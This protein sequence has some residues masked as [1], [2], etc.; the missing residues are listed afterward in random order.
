ML[1]SRAKQYPEEAIAAPEKRSS[2]DSA[3]PSSSK[4]ARSSPAAASSSALASTKSDDVFL[5]ALDSCVGSRAV[6]YVTNPANFDSF[7]RIIIEKLGGS[8]SHVTLGPVTCGGELVYFVSVEAC[9]DAARHFP[10]CMP[11]SRSQL[12]NVLVKLGTP[13]EQRITSNGRVV[14]SEFAIGYSSNLTTLVVPRS[15]ATLVWARYTAFSDEQLLQQATGVSKHASTLNAGALYCSSRA[16]P[17][18][19]LS[20]RERTLL[21]AGLARDPAT[22]FV[23]VVVAGASLPTERAS[24]LA[25]NVAR[26]SS[27]SVR[28]KSTATSDALVQVVDRE[29]AWA[30]CAVYSATSGALLSV[31]CLPDTKYVAYSAKKR[32]VTKTPFRGVPLADICAMFH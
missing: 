21:A 25:A 3:A 18:S 29:R 8:L 19:P 2:F 13:I 15:I 10:V 14:P 28:S 1:F 27:M 26:A 11:L 24:E 9:V 6:A 7:S 32:P 16:F 22:G 17:L 23:R 20:S 30:V 4:R 12:V 31:P 5:R